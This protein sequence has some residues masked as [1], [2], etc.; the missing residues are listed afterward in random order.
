MKKFVAFV[1]IVLVFAAV[2]PFVGALIVF[3]TSNYAEFSKLL[4]GYSFTSLFKGFSFVLF[5]SYIFGSAFAAVAGTF[6]AVAGLWARWNNFLVPV[7]AAL[8]ST[9]SG[10]VLVPLIFGISAEPSGFTWFFPACLGA[11][12]VCWFLT[13]RFVR[14]T[15]PSA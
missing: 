13:R 15:W 2:G 1:L 6:V 10:F 8:F 5:L 11:T 3:V 14:A 12:F 7:A 4:E 9:V